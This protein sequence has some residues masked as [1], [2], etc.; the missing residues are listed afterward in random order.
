MLLASELDLGRPFDRGWQRRCR[1]VACWY[2]CNQVISLELIAPPVANVQPSSDDRTRQLLATLSSD[3]LFLRAESK[4]APQLAAYFRDRRVHCLYAPCN[5]GSACASRLRRTPAASECSASH[6]HRS[7]SV[8]PALQRRASHP[9]GTP[10]PLS[11]RILISISITI[12]VAAALSRHSRAGRSLLEGAKAAKSRA[13]FTPSAS[14]A[15]FQRQKPPSPRP[16]ISPCLI[17]AT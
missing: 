15:V 12:N 9:A 3:H 1:G 7:E 14:T 2:M 10:D 11:S 17:A 16:V 4:P 8:P 6:R 5:P 13:T